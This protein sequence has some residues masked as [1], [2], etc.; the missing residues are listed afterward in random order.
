[1]QE[2][3]ATP[4]KGISA[5]PLQHDFYVLLHIFAHKNRAVTVRLSQR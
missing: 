4:N 3:H 1:M 5:D 2:F